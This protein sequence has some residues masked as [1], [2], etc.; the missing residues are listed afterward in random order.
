MTDDTLYRELN[1]FVD[2]GGGGD[3]RLNAGRGTLGPAG[4]Q[5]GGGAS[6]WR[7]RSQNLEMVTARIR[8]GEGSLG[9]LLNDDALSKSMTSATTNLD[10]ITG[11]INRAKARPESW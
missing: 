7:R 11:R 3:A 8:N 1:S 9:Q 4:D 2:V 6:R 5:P 10:A